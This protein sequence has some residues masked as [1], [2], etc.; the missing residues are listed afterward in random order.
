MTGSFSWTERCTTAV[1]SYGDAAPISKPPPQIHWYEWFRDNQ[2]V[3]QGRISLTTTTGSFLLSVTLAG[4][5]TFAKRPGMWWVSVRFRPT[6]HRQKD[7][8]SLQMH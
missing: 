4:R 1:P 5:K 7:A 6:L 2:T 3:Y 8:Y